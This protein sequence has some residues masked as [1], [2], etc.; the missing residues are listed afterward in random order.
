MK[1]VLEDFTYNHL[2]EVD[3]CYVCGIGS[4]DHIHHKGTLPKDFI[5]INDDGFYSKGVKVADLPTDPREEMKIS[6]GGSGAMGTTPPNVKSAVRTIE[7]EK[8][9][10]A[11]ALKLVVDSGYRVEKI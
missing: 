9:A 3:L 8:I 6:A 2:E 5:R 10:I 7:N 4:F 11:L 1:K